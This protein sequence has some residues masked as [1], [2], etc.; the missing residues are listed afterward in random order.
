M[1]ELVVVLQ[2]PRSCCQRPP[3]PTAANG[4]TLNAIHQLTIQ[5]RFDIQAQYQLYV[6][7]T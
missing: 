6:P 3:L 2:F 4:H 5:T 7:N 1:F